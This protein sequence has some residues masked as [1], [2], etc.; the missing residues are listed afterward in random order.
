MA[1]SR[2]TALFLPVALC[3]VKDSFVAAICEI[4]SI[5]EASVVAPLK[6]SRN[7]V[8]CC[9]PGRSRLG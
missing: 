3:A 8:E 2:F 5:R 1:C 4:L 7:F 6:N 9:A